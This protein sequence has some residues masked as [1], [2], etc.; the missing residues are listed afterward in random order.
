[1][2]RAAEQLLEELP[3]LRPATGDTGQA[4]HGSTL[5]T[6]NSLLAACKC[7]LGSPLA[8]NLAR[9]SS[10]DSGPRSVAA[11]LPR[12][13]LVSTPPF[14]YHMLGSNMGTL[15]VEAYN[16]ETGWSALWNRTGSRGVDWLGAAV[17]LPAQLRG[18]FWAASFLLSDWAWPPRFG[19]ASSRKNSGRLWCRKRP[20][21]GAQG[22]L[23]AALSAHAPGLSGEA[24]IMAPSMRPFVFSMALSA[25]ANTSVYLPPDAHF[26]GATLDG[27]QSTGLSGRCS[28]TQ[29]VYLFAPIAPR[30]LLTNAATIVA[31]SIAWRWSG[32]TASWRVHHHIGALLLLCGL[33]SASAKP[34]AASSS[35]DTDR[36]VWNAS[37]KKCITCIDGWEPMP[38]DDGAFTWS[39]RCKGNRAGTGGKCEACLSKTADDEHYHC[40]DKSSPVDEAD[41]WFT[42]ANSV[43]AVLAIIFVCLL[44]TLHSCCTSPPVRSRHFRLKDDAQP[45]VTTSP[46]H[47]KVLLVDTLDSKIKP[48]LQL[49]E[50]TSLV[51][52]AVLS[53]QENG[54][55]PLPSMKACTHVHLEATTCNLLQKRGL[56]KAAECVVIH[57]PPNH[58]SVHLFRAFERVPAISICYEESD[59]STKALRCFIQS[60]YKELDEAKPAG[61]DDLHN[62]CRFC[63]LKYGIGT[64]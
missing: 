5:S 58:A 59:D 15:S 51:S 56:F 40:V 16:N 25:A 41:K 12:P 17:V 34:V 19:A 8:A 23:L 29:N 44:K 30:R 53:K 4:P 13:R 26:K 50:C 55:E 9:S 2:Q 61:P 6:K 39:T 7:A 43:Y 10:P 42:F 57:N 37:L 60:W 1:M 63:N 54:F 3:P 48:M 20:T 45:T 38:D 62:A 28:P 36:Q 47:R 46:E 21:R 33:P 14:F 52:E 35:C 11:L 31:C 32:G 49:S 22:L 27:Q 64:L 18:Q 24:T